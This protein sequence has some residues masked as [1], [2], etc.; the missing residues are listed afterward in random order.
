MSLLYFLL[1][2]G[3]LVA[4]HE[5][6]HFVAAKLLGVR[7]L[8]FS[9]GFG[10]PLV[11]FVAGDTE[12]RVGIV[13]LGGYVRILGEDAATSA[14][15]RDQGPALNARPLWQRLVIVFAGPAANLVFPV[16]IYFVFFAGQQSLPAAVVGDVIADSPADRAGLEPGDRIARIDGHTVRYW[17]DVEAHIADGV[18]REL[19]LRIDRS[20]RSLERYLVPL[21][22][23][24][25]TR[26]GLERTAGWV[27]VSQAPF[28][29][30]IG[31]IDRRS[32]AGRAGLRTGDV[33]FSVDGNEVANWT[34][35]RQLLS[36]GAGR[37]AV[38]YLRG[39]PVPGLPSLEL[40]SPRVADL[41]PEASPDGGR[42]RVDTGIAPAEM[43]VRRVEAG[44]PAAEAGLRP[45]DL[46]TAIDGRPIQHWILLD[47]A[48][49]SDPARTWTLSYLRALPE[50]GADRRRALVTQDRRVVDDEYGNRG[51]RL[52]FGASNAADRGVGELVDIDGRVSY[53]LAKAIERTSETVVEM[54]TGFWSVLR[55]ESIESVGGPI[56]MYR[57]ASVSGAKGWDAFLLLLALVS[58]NLG[59]I[60]LLP[61]PMLD[62]GQ[63]VVFAVEGVSRRPLS[64]RA[65]AR[66]TSVGL[67]AVLLM[68]AFAV[69]N[70][71]LRY[72]SP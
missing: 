69:R 71:V 43:F 64:A 54:T 22:R 66:I 40:L 27:G 62:G 49:Q 67:A 18:G 10:R 20:G 19:H 57:V 36:R 47:Q 61:I 48:L 35:L 72:L 65:R 39:T 29:P 8:R 9:L 70:D 23:T 45:G 55:G 31:V 1:L 44:S 28:R 6:G 53:A 11:R 2:L 3:A 21:E 12:Y 4:V 50:G 16:L 52:A 58:V 7:V 60:N 56:T 59:L 42:Q 51:R 63:V 32:P 68:T 41:V 33:V 15:R 13:P 34:D 24:V 25:R 38:A 46:I 5:F 30:R 14:T 37:R 26:E 17:E